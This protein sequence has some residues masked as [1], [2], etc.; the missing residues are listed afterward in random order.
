[1][2]P[3]VILITGA[4]QEAGYDAVSNRF[5]GSIMFVRFCLF[6]ALVAGL[7]GAVAGVGAVVTDEAS[8]CQ[9]YKAC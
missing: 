3:G 4:H 9:A 7:A 1:M 2:V 6:V 8:A 5:Q